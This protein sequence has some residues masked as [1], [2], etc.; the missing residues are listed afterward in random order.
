[1]QTLTTSERALR[2]GILPE[3]HGW[4]GDR[5]VT[6]PE[7]EAAILDAMRATSDRPPRLRRP[8]VVGEPCTAA[9]ERTWGWSVQLYALRSRDSWGVG[10]FVD[11]RQFA[12][13]SRQ[14]GASC[15]LLNPLSAQRPMLPY[16]PSP[17]YASSRHFRNVVY[18]RVEEVEGARDVDVAEE[19]EAALRLNDERVIDYD[20]VFELKT[21][22]L[23]KIFHAAPKPRGLASYLNGEGHALRDFA[24]FNAQRNPVEAN[25]DFEVW[26]QFHLDR[27]LA[28]ASREIGLI[29]DVPVGFASDG[30]DGHR[31]RDYIAPDM[32]VG[33]PPDEFF[34]DGQDWGLPPINPWKYSEARWA[35][36]V[37]AIRS[38]GRH[39]AGVR[40]DH[41]MG[42]FRLFW[43]PAGMTAAQGAYV[44]YPARA[45]LALLANESRRAKAFIIGE[46]LGLVE[47]VVRRQLNEKGSLS[48]RL[49]W[50]ES[51][52][53][54]T[55]PRD[56]VA[57]LGT[58][59]LPT[60]AGIWTR[61]EPEHRL[62]HLR[63]KLVALTKLPDDTPP[64]DVAVAVYRHLARGR[65]RIVLASIED[66]LGVH[67][68]PNVP[69]TTDEFP[70]WRLALPL[71]L[72]EVVR[73]DGVLRIAAEMKAAGR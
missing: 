60:V 38:A 47:P 3:Y 57:A 42:L 33:A 34:R 70:N 9:P 72:E 37:D 14:A 54:K 22:A 7:V 4:Q 50:F 23:A 63:D 11:L 10:D 59:D 20:R 18:L 6:P 31:W 56:A 66:A 52:E 65:P 15:I 40:L 71:P 2:W 5:V 55:W 16:Q 12:R 49:V 61:S 67:E 30:F 36:F 53:P 28:R 48:Y 58:H 19:R 43:I 41:V 24:S 27:Q 44:K 21:R 64:V 69:G 46:D 29:T 1:M 32:R 51:S 13:W 39:A 17:Y 68:R 26:Q 8:R 35:P 62:H 25:P 73:A 45:F